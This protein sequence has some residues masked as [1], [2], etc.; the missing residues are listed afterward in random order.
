MN[1]INIYRR[2]L[3]K[4]G[5][6]LIGGVFFLSAVRSNFGAVA[7]VSEPSPNAATIRK[8]RGRTQHCTEAELIGSPVQY[9]ETK[10][11]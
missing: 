8:P 1:K 11:D 5:F 7:K 3:I 4:R 2:S 6:T 10:K 9:P